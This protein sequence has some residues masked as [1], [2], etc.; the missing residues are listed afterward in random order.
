MWRGYSQKNDKGVGV[1]NR[2]YLSLSMR[3]CRYIIALG[4]LI[5]FVLSFL[6]VSYR[7][8]RGRYVAMER[9]KYLYRGYTYCEELGYINTELSSA[10]LRVR[11]QKV[12]VVNGGFRLCYDWREIW[13]NFVIL[14]V[15]FSLL[16]IWPVAVVSKR[17][18]W[19]K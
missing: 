1:F 8:I 16:S 4:I 17:V 19:F 5:G 18:N 3:K 11:Y 2:K 13:Y 14:F 6:F 12:R 7:A 9:T 15:L 10:W